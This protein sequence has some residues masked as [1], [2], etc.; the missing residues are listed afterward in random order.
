MSEENKRTWQEF[1]EDLISDG[2]T[3]KQVLTVARHTRWQNNLEEIKVLARK[4][5]K[6]FKKSC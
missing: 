3:V 1:T 6:F 2:R 5:R 4:L